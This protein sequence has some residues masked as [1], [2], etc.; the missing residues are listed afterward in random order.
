MSPV[1]FSKFLRQSDTTSYSKSESSIRGPGQWFRAVANKSLN[2]SV[3]VSPISDHSNRSRGFSSIKSLA[4]KELARSFHRDTPPDDRLVFCHPSPVGTVPDHLLRSKSSLYGTLRDQCTPPEFALPQFAAIA[5]SLSH[6]SSFDSLTPDQSGVSNNS[7]Q[8]T[9]PSPGGHYTLN[10]LDSNQGVKTGNMGQKTSAVLKKPLSLRRRRSQAT[11]QDDSKEPSE[12]KTESTERSTQSS[13]TAQSTPVSNA[14]TRQPPTRAA[15]VVAPN[16][17]RRRSSLTAIHLNSSHFDTVDPKSTQLQHRASTL[18]EPRQRPPSAFSDTLKPVIS[19]L[20]PSTPVTQIEYGDPLSVP[21]SSPPLSGPEIAHHPSDP[22]SSSRRNSTLKQSIYLPKTFPNG[23]IPILAPPLTMCHHECY[24]MHR[25]ITVSGNTHCP[26]PCMAC[27]GSKD[28]KY[29][30]C[31]WCGLRVCG[32]CMIQFDKLGRKLDGLLAWVKGKE[33]E[34]LRKKK[35]KEPEDGQ[36]KHEQKPLNKDES[37]DRLEMREFATIEGSKEHENSSR[38][39][40]QGQADISMGAMGWLLMA[41]VIWLFGINP[42]FQALQELFA[43]LL[44][45]LFGY[46][47]TREGASNVGQ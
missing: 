44:I 28:P 12:V 7:T 31:H 5:R 10:T 6:R 16:V 21:P 26:V 11:V 3:L 9:T 42:Y 27:G 30:K 22:K 18:T 39:E 43:I 24:Q 36:K 34:A 33:E 32:P 2:D 17:P 40:I 46:R 38:A 20:G 23:P 37:D 19:S 1:M 47:F 14:G 35:L 8:P 45:M 29:W 13:K 4:L 15:I 25:R 41:F